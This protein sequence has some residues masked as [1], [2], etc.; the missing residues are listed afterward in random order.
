MAQ[1]LPTEQRW[2]L[3]RG[4]TLIALSDPPSIVVL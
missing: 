4:L 3:V 2:Y 1:W